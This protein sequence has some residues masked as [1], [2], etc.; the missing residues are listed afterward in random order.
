[1]PTDPAR[2][3]RDD[4]GTP[5]KCPVWDFHKVYSTDDERQEVRQGCTSASIG[6]LDCKYILMQHLQEDLTPIRE[7]RAAIATHLDDVK[8]MVRAGNE[9][10]RREASKT[11]DKVRKSVKL[12]YKF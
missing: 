5:E 10:A 12:G 7:R 3:R 1:M 4:A 9:K 6:C 11:M 8:D 2:V